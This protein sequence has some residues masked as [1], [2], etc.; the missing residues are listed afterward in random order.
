[1]CVIVSVS[2]LHG[3]LLK[4]IEYGR[5]VL[6]WVMV[7]TSTSAVTSFY[8]AQFGLKNQRSK[9]RCGAPGI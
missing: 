2:K 7:A 8:R 6:G 4:A 5:P 9:A 1:M 3:F